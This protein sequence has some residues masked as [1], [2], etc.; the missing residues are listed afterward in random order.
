MDKT[1]GLFKIAE[2]MQ[3]AGDQPKAIE[4]LVEGLN[5]GMDRQTL[6]GVTG[7]GRLLPWPMS[8]Q[9]TASRH[10]SL[11]TTKLWPRSSPRSTANF[12]PNNAVHYFVSYYDFYQPE[13]YMPVTDTYIEKEAMINEEIERLRHASTQALLT[14]KDVII[15]ASVSCIYGLGSPVEYEKV[16]MKIAKGM[17]MPRAEMIR[18]FVD[19]HFER[20]TADLES[21]QFRALGNMVEIMPVNDKTIYSINFEGSTISEI[22]E[23]DPTTR[24]IR[25]IMMS[26]FFS[27]PSTSFQMTSS[28][29]ALL[30]QSRPS[31]KFGSKILKKPEKISKPSA[32]SAA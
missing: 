6:L 29:S 31:S 12:F 11:P 9:S 1:L 17:E 30:K 20:T 24:A 26:F 22:L 28:Q 23:L 21:G 18:R 7:S 27:R 16:N 32:S 8:L 10:S 15:V 14:R 3:P 25:G 4:S 19:I 5:K 13:A 2:K